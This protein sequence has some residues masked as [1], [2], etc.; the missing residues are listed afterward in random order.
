E[1]GRFA[2]FVSAA[3]GDGLK[4]DG[5]VAFTDRAGGFLSRPFFPDGIDGTANGPFSVPIEQFSPFND[6]LQ[7]DLV[8]SALNRILC[9][10]PVGSCTDIPGL[11]NGLQIFQGAFP[12]SRIGRLAAALEVSGDGGDE[13]AKTAPMG[14]ADFAPPPPRA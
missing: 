5:S 3:S 6:G 13:A 11:N 2:H 1:N 4:L 9:G 10:L 7:V 8:T 12:S 14:T